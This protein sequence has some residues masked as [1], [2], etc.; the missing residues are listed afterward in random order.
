MRAREA[1]KGRTVQMTDLNYYIGDSLARM[2]PT[3]R[4]SPGIPS[5]DDQ[6]GLIR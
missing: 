2:E 5:H 1:L 3:R 4:S 6:L